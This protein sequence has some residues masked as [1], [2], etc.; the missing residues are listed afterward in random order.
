MAWSVPTSGY[1]ADASPSRW[2]SK[3][4]D[5][6]AMVAWDVAK[7]HAGPAG[8]DYVVRGGR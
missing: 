4:G 1:R 8:L 5:G 3:G 7:L 2:L 6:S